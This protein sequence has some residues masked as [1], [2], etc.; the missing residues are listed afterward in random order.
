MT[1]R[2]LVLK[3]KI[4][5]KRWVRNRNRMMITI[6]EK[7]RVEYLIIGIMMTKMSGLMILSSISNHLDS[8]AKTMLKKKTKLRM[9]DSLVKANLFQKMSHPKYWIPGW[10][11][12]MKTAMS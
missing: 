5:I 4:E 12:S 1:I 2:I 9:I 11:E 8:K 3:L 6:R 7:N 10:K